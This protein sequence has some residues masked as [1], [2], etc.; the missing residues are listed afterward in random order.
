MQLQ[1]VEKLIQSGECETVEFERP[2][3]QS[4]T[5]VKTL[6]AMLNGTGGMLLFCVTNKGNQAQPTLFHFMEGE[7][8]N[9]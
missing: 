8:A 1:D 4:T 9:E 5:A 3:D 2:T 7:P 6:R